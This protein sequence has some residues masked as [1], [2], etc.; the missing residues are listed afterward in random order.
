M[1][2]D[3]VRIPSPARIIDFMGIPS[4]KVLLL[5]SKKKLDR[6]CPMGVYD[7]TDQ[8]EF[9][10]IDPTCAIPTQVAGFETTTVVIIPTLWPRMLTPVP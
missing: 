10:C 2:V 8:C 1:L 6:M 9:V 3:Y 4:D 7:S 5:L